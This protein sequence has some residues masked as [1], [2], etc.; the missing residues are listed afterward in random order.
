MDWL[1]FFRAEPRNTASVAKERLKVVVAHQ[2]EGRA[3]HAQADRAAVARQRKGDG[4]ND[5]DPGNAEQ[6]LTHDFSPL[7]G[8]YQTMPCVAAAAASSSCSSACSGVS[9]TSS[10]A[11]R[12]GERKPLAVAWSMKAIIPSQK[13]STLSRQNGLQ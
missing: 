6:T 4:E 1:K 3:N 5:D 9:A 7:P 12:C 8:P 10:C 11:R 2:R 13:P